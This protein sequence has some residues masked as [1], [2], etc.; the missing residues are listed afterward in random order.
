MQKV[1][2]LP[3]FSVSNYIETDPYTKCFGTY[4]TCFGTS[5]TPVSTGGAYSDYGFIAMLGLAQQLKIDLLPITWQ[6][7]LG[8]IGQSQA[9]INQALVNVQT[10][11]AFKR[12]KHNVTDPLRET[13]Q[14]MV[15]LGHPLVQEHPHIVQLL[16]ICWDIS[17]DSQD[18]SKATQVW[19]VLVFEKSHLGD[20]YYFARLGKGKDLSLED[21]LKICADVGIAIRDMHLNSTKIDN[22]HV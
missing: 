3:S 2:N 1:Q 8:L 6:V 12:F 4:T 9:T 22:N 17:Q 10:S 18:I 14:E 7:I 15:I 11:F 13:V 20:L 16:G 21:R 5:A 19:P